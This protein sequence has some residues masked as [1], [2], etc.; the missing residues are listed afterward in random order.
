MT[1]LNDKVLHSLSFT[2]GSIKITR[3]VVA[4]AMSK[5]NERGDPI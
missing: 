2:M 1:T 5:H 3:D 4:R